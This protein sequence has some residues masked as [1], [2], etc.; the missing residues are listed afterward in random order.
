[1]L[2]Q[3][4]F[5]LSATVFFGYLEGKGVQMQRDVQCCMQYSQQ[6]VRTKDVL[7]FEVQTEGP[8]CSIKAI[9]LYTK[10]VVKCAD[11]RDRKVKRLLKKLRQ[12]AKAHKSMQVLPQRHLPVMSKNLATVT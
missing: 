10:K 2:L 7:K 1:M 8:D 11:P 3:T 5:M 9:I 6:N 4:I 12:R